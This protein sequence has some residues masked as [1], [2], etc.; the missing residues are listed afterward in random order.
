MGDSLIGAAPV[1]QPGAVSVQ[2]VSGTVTGQQ[3]VQAPS[4]PV[5]QTPEANQP[6]VNY[7][8]SEQLDAAMDRIERMFQS[9]SDKSY[10]KV[11]KMI[12]QMQ[13]AGIK[14]PTADQA[15]AMLAAT[16]QSEQQGQDQPEAHGGQSAAA[17][18]EAEAWIKA[19]G[20]DVTQGFWNDIYD[21]AQEAGVGMITRDD[22]EFTQ[23]FMENGQPKTFAKGRHM[24]RAFEQAFEA[25]KQRLGNG[26][27]PSGTVPGNMASSPALG[28]GGAKSTYR[29]PKT[30][31]RSD[32]ISAGLR[33]PRRR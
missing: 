18:P 11:Q 21:V 15:R 14:N 2:G 19:N 31:D 24:V 25:K 6:Q 32:L 33:E 27:V 23:F 22:P 29:D 5:T 4:G 28:S 26:T 1:G 13:Q 20:G 12:E 16:G 3:G 7:V 8:T 17:S 10:N 9:R 30:V